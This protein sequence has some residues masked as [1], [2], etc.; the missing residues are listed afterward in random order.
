MH[1]L[2]RTALLS[3]LVSAFLIVACT[4]ASWAKP[5]AISS[6]S[7]S[8]EMLSAGLG[9]PPY[10]ME[11]SVKSV[12]G[13]SESGTADLIRDY[14]TE[15]L[16]ALG[17]VEFVKGVGEEKHPAVLRLRVWFTET[18]RPEAYEGYDLTIG[19]VVGKIMKTHPQY[20]AVLDAYALA[21]IKE[22]DLEGMCNKIA[23]RLDLRVLSVLR[24]MRKH[25]K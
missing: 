21:G 20:E 15:D 8:R 4:S 3:T 2:F 10:K 6:D 23:S 1:S 7:F 24:E 5:A 11:I 14:L 17:E 12:H 9:Y 16:K 22:R 18:P 25:P 13:T 19:V